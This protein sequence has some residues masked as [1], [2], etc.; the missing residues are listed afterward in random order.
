L[1]RRLQEM[2]RITVRLHP[3]ISWAGRAA[4]EVQRYQ[5]IQLVVLNGA[6]QMTARE[7][8]GFDRIG[9]RDRE[10]HGVDVPG[11]ADRRPDRILGD[12]PIER[13]RSGLRIWR[14]QRSC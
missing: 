7:E 14:I 9:I 8:S 11:D 5:M 3:E 2:I 10:I 4:S 1:V 13:A 6:G 12:A